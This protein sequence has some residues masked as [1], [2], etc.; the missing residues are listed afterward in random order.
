MSS[1]C[2]EHERESRGAQLITTQEV[3]A[4]IIFPVLVLVLV[5]V[6]DKVMHSQRPPDNTYERDER[7]SL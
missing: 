4:H 6:L 3:T 7:V 1:K 2:G 5:I